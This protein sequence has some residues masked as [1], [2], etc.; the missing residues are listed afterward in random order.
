[1]KSTGFGGT[2]NINE[3]SMRK[4][5]QLGEENKIGDSLSNRIDEN[6][7]SIVTHP[8]NIIP[9]NM[10]EIFTKGDEFIVAHVC[11]VP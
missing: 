1:L 6:V 7:G 3:N 11:S 9:N 4:I 2:E 5:P 8:T 10:E